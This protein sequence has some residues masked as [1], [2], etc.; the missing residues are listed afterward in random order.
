MLRMVWLT[1]ADILPIP[2]NK[3]LNVRVHS[4]SRLAANRALVQL[5]E[6][7]NNA[8]IKYPVTEMRLAFE[9]GGYNIPDSA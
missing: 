8:Q 6:H 7:P 9:L 3:K 4:A 1:E 2:E 5:F